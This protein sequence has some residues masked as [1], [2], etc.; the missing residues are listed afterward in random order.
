VA[1]G[2]NGS[3]RRLRSKRRPTVSVLRIGHRAGRDPRL[4]THVALAARALGAD[5]LYLHPPDHD[6]AGR[7]ATVG[8][9]FGGSFRVEGVDSWKSTIREFDGTVVHLTMYGEPLDR[10]L[11]KLRTRRRILLVVGGAKVPSELYGLSGLNVA[12]GHQPHSEVAAMAVVLD[13]L[14]GVPGPTAWA[15]ARQVIVPTK[16]GK[17]VV[18]RGDPA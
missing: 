14:L 18:T 2:S 11:P 15:N 17:R 5:T 12:V 4:T 10:V 1:T 13:R 7:L 3:P 8:E 16:R 6:L 9:R